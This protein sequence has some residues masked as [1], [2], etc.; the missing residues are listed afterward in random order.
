MPVPGFTGPGSPS[1]NLILIPRGQ[2]NV[3]DPE[4]TS[5]YVTFVLVPEPL[6]DHENFI[7]GRN[8]QFSIPSHRTTQ[9]NDCF[10]QFYCGD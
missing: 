6:T 3:D 9:V 4:Q 7:E 5:F 2:I 8:A 1:G 10:K